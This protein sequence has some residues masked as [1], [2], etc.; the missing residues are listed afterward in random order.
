VP[1][2]ILHRVLSSHDLPCEGCGYNLRGCTTLFCPECGMVIPRPAI[3]TVAALEKRHHDLLWCPK[4]RYPIASLRAD[5]CPDCGHRLV[6]DD[7]AKPRRRGV[8]KGVPWPLIFLAIFAALEVVPIFS[9]YL[10]STSR[11]T[12]TSTAIAVAAALVPLSMAALFWLGRRK[13]DEM[14]AKGFWSL[15]TLAAILGLICITAA[16]RLL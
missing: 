4:C 9:K 1:D 15:T 14:T 10:T 12:P 7:S 11:L 8:V 6:R 13:L 3:E 5:A 16:A 2:P